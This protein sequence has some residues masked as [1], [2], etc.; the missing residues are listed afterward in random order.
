MFANSVEHPRSGN[1]HATPVD[2][3]IGR[4]ER[5]K[6]FRTPLRWQVLFI[7]LGSSGNVESTTQNLSSHGFYCIS[8]VP[9]TPGERYTCTMK[10]PA[11][12]PNKADRLLLLECKVRIL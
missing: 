11:H 5:R 9:S 10:V 8:P 1:G 6:W 2:P 4:A 7:G 12:Q 3:G